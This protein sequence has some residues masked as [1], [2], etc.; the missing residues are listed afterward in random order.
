MHYLVG[1]K[2]EALEFEVGED[3][4]HLGQKL[5]EIQLKPNILLACISRKGRPIF[6]SGGDWLQKGDTVVVVTGAN[7]VIVELRDIFAD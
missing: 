6:P 3:T 7:R 2:V 5:S 4:P 1:G